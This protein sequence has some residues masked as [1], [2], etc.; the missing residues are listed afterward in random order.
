ME[1]AGV[2]TPSSSRVRGGRASVALARSE[3]RE[4]FPAGRPRARD[5]WPPTDDTEARAV[6]LARGAAPRRRTLAAIAGQI[7]ARRAWERLGFA[8]LADYARERPGL[9]ARSLQ[10]LARVDAALRSLPRVEAALLSGALSWTSVRLLCRVARP[11]DEPR[12]IALARS[13]TA[14]ALAREV[15]A[16]EPEASAGAEAAGEAE[17]ADAVCVAVRC[18]PRVAGLFHRAR[19][20][21][22]R[23]AGEHLPTWGCME[24]VAAEGLSALADGGSGPEEE[25][26]RSGRAEERRGGEAAAEPGTGRRA[27]PFDPATAIGGAD[28]FELDAR[29]RRAVSLEQR[30]EAE[31]A[32]LVLAV[33]EGGLHRLRG[34]SS[35]E[36]WGLERLGIAPR[37]LRAL[38][39]L[40]RACASWPSL[41]DAF[42]SGRLSWVR[43]HAVI[44]ALA[45]ARSPAEGRAWLA[46]AE[47]VSVRRLQ[48]EVDAAL[49][50][51]AEA[52][53]TGERQT[54]AQPVEAEAEDRRVVFY[55]PLPA[56]RVFRAA[57]CA[58]RRH[59][60]LAL[61]RP[62][63][64]GEAAG[65]LFEHAIATWLASAG[66]DPRLSRA[67]RVF[68]RDGWRCTIPGCTS[69]RNLHDH[70][71]RFRSAGGTDALANR[72]TLCAFHH[73]RGVHAGRVRVT[74]TAPD[75]LRF[76]LGLR[77][78]RAPLV[79][80]DSEET[81]M[82]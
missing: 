56:A 61:G 18:A 1:A 75:R 81:M 16:A 72:T 19:W 3:A 79:R 55:A 29:L 30:F 65:W 10:D 74:G 46:R 48:D 6:A 63:S 41:A 53:G 73:L 68:A 27:P 66:P 9:S 54:G 39:R 47:R 43:A 49:L 64:E 22:R 13:V 28:A 24:A 42:R 33:A 62:A 17:E 5:P 59:L 77:T 32:P 71:V 25:D 35:L 11:D 8:R 40:A 57:L 76:E 58:A 67:H 44:P 52:A 12:W 21:A 51:A 78:G 26:A 4:R 37:K 50:A 7:V 15:R 60:A 31:L 45:L 34:F 20:L 70:H 14:R 69:Y 38:R 36:A 80:Y 2:A 82:P 23:A